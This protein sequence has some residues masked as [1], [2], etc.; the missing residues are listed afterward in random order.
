[1]SLMNTA[2]Y[3]G[4]VMGMVVFQGIFDSVISAQS[5][6]VDIMQPIGAYHLIIPKSALLTGFQSAFFI[7]MSISVVIIILSFLSNEKTNT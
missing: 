2:R 4:L 7:G 6:Q 5:N 1:S 3:L